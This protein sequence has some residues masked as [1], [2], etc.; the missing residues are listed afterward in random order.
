M[1]GLAAQKTCRLAALG[2]ETTRRAAA[3]LIDFLSKIL[4]SKSWAASGLYEFFDR[5]SVSPEQP[6]FTYQDI[7]QR[8]SVAKIQGSDAGLHA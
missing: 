8:L 2:A 5:M 7:K 1:Q 4:T 3:Q 6:M